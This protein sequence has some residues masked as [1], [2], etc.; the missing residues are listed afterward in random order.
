MCL[1]QR[2]LLLMVILLILNEVKSSLWGHEAWP[3][4]LHEALVDSSQHWSRGSSVIQGSI[5]AKGNSRAVQH[6]L[7]STMQ[8]AIRR[9]E[10]AMSKPAQSLWGKNRLRW[11]ALASCD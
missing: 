10:R 1:D 11:F 4:G 3:S 5:D 7:Q 2:K 9:V 6:S 8:M